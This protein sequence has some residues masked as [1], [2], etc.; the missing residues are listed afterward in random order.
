MSSMAGRSPGAS[1]RSCSIGTPEFENFALAYGNG[2]ARRR[3]GEGAAHCVAERVRGRTGKNSSTRKHER[4]KGD[5]ARSGFGVSR[6]DSA[7]SRNREGTTKPRCLCLPPRFPSL[8]AFPVGFAVS[9]TLTLERRRTLRV[10]FGA[11]DQEYLVVR[12]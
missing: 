11:M 2:A 7:E 6:R 10:P 9:R 1:R 12:D 5:A 4:T 3:T 8:Y